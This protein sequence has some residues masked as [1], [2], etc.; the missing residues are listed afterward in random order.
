[1]VL[2]CRR[3]DTLGRGHERKRKPLTQW[4]VSTPDNLALKKW[5]QYGLARDDM[6]AHTH[7]PIAPWTIVRDD[8]KQLARLNITKD[9]LS[10]FTIPIRTSG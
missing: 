1:M 5:K 6:L 8:D 9:L 2:A 4:K 7:N 3:I 10:R